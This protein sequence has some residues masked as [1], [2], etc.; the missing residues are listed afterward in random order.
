ML[1]KIQNFMRD[2]ALN[3]GRKEVSRFND[4]LRGMTDEDMGIVLA[5][6]TVIRVNM[7][8]EKYL[9]VDLFTG[10]I[11]PTINE[12]GK[13]QMALNKLAKQF[14]KMGQP[15]D[16]VGAVVLSLSMRCLNVIELLPLG[17]EM[18]EVLARGMPHVEQ[19]LK[20]GEEQKGEPFP[21][22]V[23]DECH[24]IP[25]GLEPTGW[26]RKNRRPSS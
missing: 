9:P 3:S 10:K 21:K 19:A 26:K 17:R 24:M 18:W 2:Q 1:K 6:A 14:N 4:G 15:T 23:W 7:E 22:Q 5:V 13:Y 25:A 16:A 20:D 11:T 8:K 12:L